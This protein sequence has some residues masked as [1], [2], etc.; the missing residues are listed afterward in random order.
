MKSRLL[1]AWCLLCGAAFAAPTPYPVVIDSQ[2]KVETPSLTVMQGNERTFRITFKD[3][4][5]ASSLGTQTP[6]LFWATNDT[7]SV[8][9]TASCAVV[10]ATNGTV[11]CTFSPAALNYTPGKWRYWA[12]L[13]T[14]TGNLTT[15]RSGTFTISGDPQGAGAGAVTWTT[16]VNLALYN[17]S[18]QLP[19]ANVAT[20]PY[21]PTMTN[22]TTVQ[23]GVLNG[24]NG[25]Y[26]VPSG[27]TNR[28]W[29]LCP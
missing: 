24:T 29:I 13:R 7:A 20:L 17:F 27:S 6:F 5:V 18:G 8:V 2:S 12:G 15:Y 10:V 3:N 23:D 21:L 4:G 22:G 1:A 14:S 26:F 11:D 9:S 28:Y 19:S 25:V 16:N